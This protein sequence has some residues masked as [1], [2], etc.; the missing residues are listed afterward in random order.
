M[1]WRRWWDALHV[2]YSSNVFN[3]GEQK[4]K[5]NL[6]FILKANIV[7]YIMGWKRMNTDIDD[8]TSHFSPHMAWFW[9]H[10]DNNSDDDDDKG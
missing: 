7:D 3:A 2:T 8:L 5:I 6:N 10:N 4:G 9:K 1:N